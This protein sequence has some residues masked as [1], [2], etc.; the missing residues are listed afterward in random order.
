MILDRLVANTTGSIDLTDV[1]NRIRTIL[2]LDVDGDIG[3]ISDSQ[4]D[5]AV[6]RIDSRGRNV[7]L[8]SP[9]AILIDRIDAGLADVRLIANSIDDAS[10][11]SIV[12][13]HWIAVVPHGAAG[14]WKSETTGTDVGARFDGALRCR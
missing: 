1:D 7:T 5:L 8:S 14:I 13:I 4:Q 9:R 12:D 10:D 6:V 2:R 11:D 3:A